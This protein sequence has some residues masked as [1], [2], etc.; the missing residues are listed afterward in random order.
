MLKRDDSVIA[1]LNGD[2]E[3]YTDTGLEK[4]RMYKYSIAAE[5]SD[6]Q[7]GQ[8]R[9]SAWAGGSKEPGI[10]ELISFER[11]TRN[12]KLAYKIP[13]K[14]LD[15]ITPFVNPISLILLR[16]N[17]TVALKNDL[18]INDTGTV[19]ELNDV[20]VNNGFYYYKAFVR[21]SYGNSSPFSDAKLLYAGDNLTDYSDDFN[22][23]VIRN[24]LN[25]SGWGL[26][27][28]FSRTGNA[29]TDSPSSDY[30]PLADSAIVIFPYEGRGEYVSL[31]FWHSVFVQNR[32]SAIVEYSDDGRNTWKMITYFDKEMYTPWNDGIK[33]T[34]DWKFERFSIKAE[35][36]AIYF[37]FRLRSNA[38]KNDD[39]WYIDDISFSTPSSADETKA[40]QQLI[41]YPNPADKFI[42]IV[43]GQNLAPEYYELYN[44]FGEKLYEGQVN[45]FQND[46]VTID[47]MNLQAGFYTILM[48]SANKNISISKFIKM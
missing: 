14:R 12:V 9:D 40:L 48:K 19:I 43:I 13:S 23:S 7:S 47:I 11:N 38:T 29:L 36:S 28:T 30:R 37:R 10:P 33:S 3:T 44:I 41:I 18:S 39:G 21:D 2:I 24:Y 46:H 26:T 35:S 17:D 32:D 4:F 22:E 16:D 31:S 6:L 27:S 5:Y 34:D 42:N 45:I 25:Q 20:L 1:K 15:G 8:R